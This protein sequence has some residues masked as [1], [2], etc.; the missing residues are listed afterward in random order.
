MQHKRLYLIVYGVYLL[1]YDVYSFDFDGCLAH[2]GFLSAQQK[3]IL[4]ANRDLLE[5]LK[6]SPNPKIAFV[7]SNR[8]SAPDDS[9]NSHA[10]ERGSCFPAISAI[11]Q[12]LNAVLD[13]FLLSDLYND[14]P[15]GTSFR[16]ALEHIAPNKKDY[17][18][19]DIKLVKGLP[20]WIHDESKLTLLYA[21][22][23]KIASEHPNDTINFNFFDDRE[24]LLDNLHAY[25]S[26]YPELIPGNVTLK[27]KQYRGPVDKFDKPIEPQVKEYPSIQ[28]SRT[29]YDA[30]YRQTVKDMAAVTIEEMTRQGID[31][32]TSK[33]SRPITSFAEAKQ[34]QFD[35]SPIKCIRYYQPGMTLV[36]KIQAPE[37]VQPPV[38]TKKSRFFFG[39][40]KQE[41]NS[42]LSAASSSSSSA[43]S[44]TSPRFASSSSSSG[45]SRSSS[46]SSSPDDPNL[47]AIDKGKQEVQPE[48]VVFGKTVPKPIKTWFH[49]PMG[50]HR[51][52]GRSTED[53]ALS[54]ES[55][56]NGSLK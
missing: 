1:I 25:F 36:P 50:E 16:M 23:H 51:R 34:N 30:D 21:Q 12:E 42:N 35:M 19:T 3:D 54:G 43:D 18:P 9:T 49:Q 45:S 20:N 6:A 27:L 10:D 48:P 55:P 13:G 46:T 39:S 15:D 11:S 56:T 17:N 52:K 8:Q 26:K 4:A 7:G 38:K 14:L 5:S 40:R 53:T 24:D 33:S 41:S 32:T 2:V 47:I 28:G 37:K 31:I 44:P 22:I 29:T